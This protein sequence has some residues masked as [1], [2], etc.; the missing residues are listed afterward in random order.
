MKN[1]RCVVLLH[2]IGATIGAS[3]KKYQ[4][5]ERKTFAFKHKYLF[6]KVFVELK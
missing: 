2:T 5:V 4:M 6:M 3:K 1:Q